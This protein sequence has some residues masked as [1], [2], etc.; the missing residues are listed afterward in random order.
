MV[1]SQLSKYLAAVFERQHGHYV[2]RLGHC[3]AH[4]LTLALDMFFPVIFLHSLPQ[5]GVC[6]ADMF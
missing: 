3:M 2:G 4:G 5:I 6:S 1:R